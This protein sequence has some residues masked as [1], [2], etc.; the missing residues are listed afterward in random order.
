MRKGNTNPLCKTP[1][2]F[3][4]CDSFWNETS[5]I[6]KSRHLFF[7][8]LTNEHFHEN[9]AQHR[10]SI[11]ET[12]LNNYLCPLLIIPYHSWFKCPRPMDF[13]VTSW[14]Q[15]VSMSNP[16]IP[17]QSGTSG[18]FLNMFDIFPLAL[19]VWE[20]Y[21]DLICHISQLD[22]SRICHHSVYYKTNW[23]DKQTDNS[24]QTKQA[25]LQLLLW[26]QSDLQLSDPLIWP[27]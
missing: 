17:M 16:G 19:V 4:W 13:Q 23:Q 3:N 25:W 2:M 10:L 6:S 21:N 26:K 27:T 7:F 20:W 18:S 11:K 12:V 1:R 22:H 8:F 24:R 15:K 9:K 14:C 5:T